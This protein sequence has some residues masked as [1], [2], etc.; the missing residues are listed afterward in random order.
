MFA[1][2]KIPHQPRTSMR[3]SPCSLIVRTSGR[4]EV[5]SG[6]ITATMFTLPPPLNGSTEAMVVTAKLTCP[7]ATSA[8]AGPVPL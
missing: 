6:A 7:P 3:E 8:T 1:G 4:N 5:R 2:P